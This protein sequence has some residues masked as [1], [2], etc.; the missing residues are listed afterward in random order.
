MPIGNTINCRPVSRIADIGENRWNRCALPPGKDVENAPYNPFLNYRFLHALE[1]SG[2]ATSESGWTPHHM[3]AE[4]RKGEILGVMPLYLKSHSRG[5]YV[6]DF[7]WADAYERAGGAY[8]PKFQS[9]VPFTPVAG[10]RILVSPIEHQQEIKHQLIQSAI[11]CLQPYGA[12]SLHFT[13]IDRD[14][15]EYL[16]KIGFLQR[17]DQQFHW[18]NE[19]YRSFDQF[20]ERFSSK[21]RRNIKRERRLALKEGLQIEHLQGREIREEHWEV[22]YKFYQDTGKRKWGV[23][24]LN[25]TFFLMIGE[26]MADDIV[27]ILCRHNGRYVAGALNFL[28]SDTLY[29]RYWG[30]I[31]DHAYLHFEVCYYQALDFAINHRLNRVEAGAQGEHKLSRGY[32]PRYTYSAH[33]ITH[34]GFRDAIDHYLKSETQLVHE[35]HL[36]LH[37]HSPFRRG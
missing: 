10:R 14:D 4:N 3:V 6:F 16:G 19:G 25:K 22:F 34:P 12:S 1:K 2:S 28:G 13:F 29:G 18:R 7:A 30:C 8:Y 23:P 33:W 36:L 5:E 24:Y 21:K 32:L 37:R 15:W 26:E 17:M 20:L 27:L 9:A 31:E 35:D 11:D